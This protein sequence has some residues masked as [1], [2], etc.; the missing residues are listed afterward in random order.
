MRNQN[1]YRNNF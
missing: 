1:L